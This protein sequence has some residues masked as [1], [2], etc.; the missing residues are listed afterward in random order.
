MKKIKI[1]FAILF[2]LLFVPNIRKK[3]SYI[4]Y[5]VFF[6]NNTKMALLIKM[7]TQIRS[8]LVWILFQ[9]SVIYFQLRIGEMAR[10]QPVSEM[11]RQQS[12]IVYPLLS[13]PQK[14][15]VCKIKVPQQLWQCLQNKVI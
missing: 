13:R 8:V 5:T 3:L 15:A 1:F 12:G 2:S 14:Q 4:L 6:L 11:L 9:I 7:T 10:V